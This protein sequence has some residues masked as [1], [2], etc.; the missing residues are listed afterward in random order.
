MLNGSHWK[1]NVPIVV[2]KTVSFW[3]A[4]FE[5][6]CQNLQEVPRVEYTLAPA[7]LG[8]I[9]SNIRR[10]YLL[11]LTALFKHFRSTHMCTYSWSFFS[12]GLI[13]AHQSEDDET[14]SIMPRAS[15]LNLRQEGKWDAAWRGQ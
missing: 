9:S 14:C 4:A 10:I 6:I 3:L 8:A 12:N 11:C 1:Q 7:S 2:R 5:E 13:G 15:R